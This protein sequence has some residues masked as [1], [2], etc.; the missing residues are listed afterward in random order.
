MNKRHQTLPLFAALAIGACGDNFSP[1]PDLAALDIDVPGD[2]DEDANGAIAVGEDGDAAT[3]S[4]KLTR[5][6]IAAVTMSV[7][8]SDE[9]AGIASASELSFTAANYSEPQT[10]EIT[11]IDDDIAGGDRPFTIHLGQLI[12]DDPAF[13]GIP[14]RS[15]SFVSRDD[16]VAGFA[17]SDRSGMTTESNGVGGFKIALT[18][19]PVADVVLELAS[20]DTSEGWVDPTLTFTAD[21]WN[22][23][24]TVTVTGADDDLD[25]GTSRYHIQV[26]ANSD[27]AVYAALE[28]V[29][30]AMLNADNDTAGVAV[31]AISGSTTEAGGTATFDVVLESEPI[32]DVTIAVSSTK[33][34]EALGP[35]ADLTFTAANWDQV[36][37]VEVTGQDDFIDD[38][39][40]DYE[41]TLD[42]SSNDALYAAMTPA[43]VAAVNLDDDTAGI[44]MS[45]F[46][47]LPTESGGAATFDLS[48]SSEPVA[49]VVLTLSGDDASEGSL[50]DSELTFTAA[51]WNQVRTITVTGVDDDI[52]DGTQSFNVAVTAAS[53]D[54]GYNAL[55]PAN[56]A[57]LNA[58]NDTAGVSVATI[59]APT[60]EAGGTATFD[61]VLGSEPI[62]DVTLS[63]ASS[64]A[65]E[66]TA[67]APITFTSGNW[68]VSQTV[69]VTGVDDDIDD[70]DAEYQIDISIASEDGQYAAMELAPVAATNV[71]DDTAA[72][73]MG[74]I[75]GSTTEAGGIATFDVVLESEPT[76]DVVVTLSANDST[77]GTI[78]ASL[79]FTPESWDAA[80]TATVTGLDDDIDDGEVSYEVTASVA[81]FDPVYDG[82]AV[83]PLGVT[84]LDDDTAGVAVSAISGNTT[85]DGGTATFTVALESQPLAEVVVSL[86]VD[87]PTEGSL[88]RSFLTF[89]AA[90]WDLPELVT[91]TGQP[92]A[93]ADGDVTYNLTFVITSQDAKYNEMP[94]APL[95]VTNQDVA[96][97]TNVFHSFDDGDLS[98]FEALSPDVTM[99]INSEAAAIGPFG[100]EVTG[101]ADDHFKGVRS[102]VAPM[103]PA[104]VSVRMMADDTTGARSYFVLGDENVAMNF[105]VLFLYAEGSTWKAVGGSSALGV[106]PVTPFVYER[107]EFFL[108][109][110]TRT[111]DIRLNGSPV[112]LDLPFRDSAFATTAITEMHL[113]NRAPAT[114]SYDEI[115]LSCDI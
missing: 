9:T 25:D 22:Q 6:P 7:T 12:S 75:S 33:P 102:L 45:S 60:T 66:G 90:N 109:W 106:A 23:P 52:A 76:S 4:L 84:N 113:Y 108:D 47:G 114:A 17:I 32:A 51:D 83:A 24:Q 8:S 98:G 43:P 46:S 53:A 85:E 96:V 36:Q 31:S 89:T 15:L 112:V 38:G 74:P 34:G 30:V 64:D 55:D 86:G 107:F 101:V 115:V 26:S 79:T 48:L 69:T 72:V 100:L 99:S 41:I 2:L 3:F 105:G 54:P 65:T 40:A 35:L 87:D 58:D 63:F 57:L 19:E 91:V 110:N 14:G 49:D 81:S 88:D 42:V 21:D 27:D 94:L 56:V 5:A 29:A 111:M 18:S 62:A 61:V 16:D 59:S 71:D 92:D 97:C 80:Q 93:D 10:I 28:P 11:A 104:Y 82:L 68:D 37:T 39:D 1:Q 50:S 13:H 20:S 103:Q 78:G 67:G 95:A 70:G 73:A 77:E 44:D